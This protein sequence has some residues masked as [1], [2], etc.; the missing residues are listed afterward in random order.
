[1]AP[2][3]SG[4]TKKPVIRCSSTDR[5]INCPGSAVLESIIAPRASDE[6]SWEGTM[7]HW[8][9]AWRCV[10]DLGAVQPDGGIPM[11]LGVPPG[12]RLPSYVAWI[13][14]W[15]FKVAKEQSPA[16]WALEVEG[17]LQW[18]FDHFILQGHPDKYAT[19]P[20]GIHGMDN[21]WKA[22]RTPVLPAEVNW[23]VASYMALR[24]RIYGL[25]H[26]RY[27]IDQPWN[28]E[29][30]GFQRQSHVELEGLALEKNT[31]TLEE[32]INDSLSDASLLNTGTHCGYCVGLACPALEALLYDMKMRLTPEILAGI[33]TTMDDTKLVDLVAEARTLNRPIEDAEAMLKDR[34]ETNPVLLGSDGREARIKESS[35]GFKVV[36][37]VGMFGWLKGLMSDA[38]LAPAL[39]Y[40]G[41]RIKDQIAKA[42]D[43]PASGK[44]PMTAKSVF[45]GGA[46]PF[47]EPTV[48]K[49]IIFT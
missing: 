32:Y 10:R 7:I 19:S 28:D 14:D 27:E 38:Q 33:K 43:I 20:D 47:I 29:E 5:R 49:Q 30:A 12:Y 21:D 45:E 44:A 36:D 25:K 40:P 37:P 48:K 17:E 2:R 4:V 42:M 31:T 8:E 3:V 15:C 22:G 16:G 13:V 24:E 46:A 18:E 39:S 23:Q 26:L 41:G 34:L 1:M 6:V 9:V 35:G 11:P